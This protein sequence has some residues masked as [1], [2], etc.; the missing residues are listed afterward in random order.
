MYRF[1]AYV[2]LKL[3]SNHSSRL[4][5]KHLRQQHTLGEGIFYIWYYLELPVLSMIKWFQS[6]LLL[7]LESLETI[8]PLI[9]WPVF[10]SHIVPLSVCCYLREQLV[11]KLYSL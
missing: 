6:V 5:L 2:L 9:A 4:K 7:Y 11:D 1:D 8:Y 10:A 3:N